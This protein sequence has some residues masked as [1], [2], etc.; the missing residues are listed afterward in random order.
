MND[1]LL[2]VLLEVGSAY[3]TG[4]RYDP[5]DRY[6]DFQAVFMADDRGR[7][8]L[9]EIL[10]CSGLLHPAPEREAETVTESVLKNEGSRRLALMIL[11]VAN[12]EPMHKR[13]ATATNVKPEEHEA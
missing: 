3:P 9:Q 11:K 10:R 7:R 5:M 13:P 8:V 2:D 12:Q 6:R 4:G 1:N